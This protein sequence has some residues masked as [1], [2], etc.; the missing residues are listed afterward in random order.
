MRVFGGYAL[1]VESAS[2]DYIPPTC[3]VA[4]LSLDSWVEISS[5]ASSASLSSTNNDIITTGLQVRSQDERQSRQLQPSPHLAHPQLRST[6]TAGS[7]QDEYEESESESDRV[8][9]SSNE[10]IYQGDTA[11]DDETSTALG[12]DSLGK[13]FTPQ[14]NAFSHPPSSHNRTVPDPYFP[15]GA[16]VASEP[17]ADRTLTQRGYQRQMQSRNRPAS[18]PYQPD[19]DAAL[20]ASLTTLLSC[21]AAVRPKGPDARPPP[22][23][24][25]TQPT[26]LRL[27]P[28]SALEN[29]PGQRRTSS[30][31]K[32]TKRK[33]RESS[34]DRPAAKKVRA[35]GAKAAAAA[36]AT[37][38]ELIS[39]T[40]ASWMISAGVVLVFSAISFSAGY[41]WGREVGRI[42][43]E[44]GLP[45][46]SC[47]QESI[48]S[49]GTGL[50]RLRWSSAASSIRA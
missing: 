12:V 23:R 18:S 50:R 49:T 27:V 35:A 16:A 20:R 30:P 9:S 46:G 47:G 3:R 40:L 36:E 26:T 32:Q 2:S 38:E 31:T 6:S 29:A 15:Q 7:S 37:G 21:A 17:Q 24:A 42:E 41:A 11:D 13:V 1:K 5:R 4:D 19:H 28:E 22:Q 48:R 45:G 25:S 43:G 8:L 34:K 14:P 33:S 10:E 39:P 44:M